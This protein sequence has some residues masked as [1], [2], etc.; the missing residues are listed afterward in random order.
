MSKATDYIIGPNMQD[1][2]H[3]IVADPLTS[4]VDKIPKAEGE[5]LEDVARAVS[6]MAAV[7]DKTGMALLPSSPPKDGEDAGADRLRVMVLKEESDIGVE[8]VTFI[9]CNR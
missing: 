5:Q 7:T 8:Q 2:L 4:M 3:E 1:P 6:A 9:W